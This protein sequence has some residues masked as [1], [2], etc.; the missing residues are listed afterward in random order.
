M[1]FVSN[2]SS[3]YFVNQINCTRSKCHWMCVVAKYWTKNSFH[4]MTTQSMHSL[5]YTS[6]AYHN[7]KIYPNLYSSSVKSPSDKWLAQ[8]MD[9]TW[10]ESENATKWMLKKM[11]LLSM[12]YLCQLK[13]RTDKVQMKNTNNMP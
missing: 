2:L 10:Y 6:L 11:Q 13:L 9:E 5:Q 12:N 1:E 7:K 3:F 4:V 8:F